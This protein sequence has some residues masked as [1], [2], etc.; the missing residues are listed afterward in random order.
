[1]S[2]S[3]SDDILLLGSVRTAN[4]GVVGFVPMRDGGEEEEKR[5]KKHE[6]GRGDERER[7][8]GESE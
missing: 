4:L 8:Q 1:M 6:K 3:R 2:G 7:R 5:R